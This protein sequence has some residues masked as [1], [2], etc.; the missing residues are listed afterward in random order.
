MPIHFLI[1]HKPSCGLCVKL[2][3]ITGQQ[4]RCTNLQHRHLEMA[5]KLK[6]YKAGRVLLEFLEKPRDAKLGHS[7]PLTKEICKLAAAVA[8]EARATAGGQYL[9]SVSSRYKCVDK[10]L[11]RLASIAL[12]TEDPYLIQAC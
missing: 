6:I 10:A 4:P 11:M 8:E 3:L 9:T 5:D 2:Q 1:A 12:V 7:Q